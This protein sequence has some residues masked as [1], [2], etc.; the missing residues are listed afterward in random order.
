MPRT[1]LV[2][3][4]NDLRLHDHEA[5]ATAAKESDRVVPVYCV[6][7]RHYRTTRWGVEKTGALRA[8]FLIESLDDLRRGYRELGA[9]LVIRRGTPE[10]V[11]P[12][13]VRQ[14]EADAVHVHQEV[15]TEEVAVEEAVEQ[16]LAETDATLHT[17]WGHTLYHVDDIPFDQSGIP[18][19]YTSFRKG[20][21]KRSAVRPTFPRPEHLA[22]L[23]D[24]LDPGA[25]PTVEDLGL[26]PRSI[27]ERGVL[28]FTGGETAGLERV[29]AYLWEQDLLKRYKETRNGLLGAD[30][31]SKFSAWLA[32]GCLS[33]RT[34]YEEVKAYEAERVK[35]KSTYWLVFELIWRDFFRYV[36]WKVGDR[37]FHPSG[38]M[39]KAIDWTGD[40]EAFRH[41]ASGTTGF[42]F[43][44][45]NMR[46]L[47]ETGFM[48]NRG[49]QNVASFL[50]KNLNL[51]WRRGAAY[52]EARLIDYD[53]TS[54]WG[55]W[56][57]V[58]GVGNDP[59][60][61]YFNIVSQA[62]RY[63]PDGAYV[64][65][66]L[67]ELRDVP[68]PLVHE[69]YAMSAMEQQMH[70]V[71]IGEDYPAPMIDLEASYERLQ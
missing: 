12:D 51:D 3:L 9:D 55:N 33:P 27:D 49:R 17:F 61:R 11:L 52:F 13:L 40:D 1:T 56:A 37:L 10:D 20:V 63:D 35:N 43:I 48:S 30:Y 21:E 23:P 68:D 19:V 65:H 53:V 44:D 38:P 14:V 67:P 50:A 2:W 18:N 8:Q 69:P 22:A 36:G 29:Q 60:D 54:N 16:A 24:D 42:P 6:D 4:R 25:M 62:K 47:N 45:A 46:E 59:R 58:A 39:N 32:H 28:D 41:W 66:W 34:I 5:L 31:S 7:P 15:T 71:T 57:Y 26:T 64:K 70:G